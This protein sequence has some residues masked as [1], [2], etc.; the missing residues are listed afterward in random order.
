MAVLNRV[1]YFVVVLSAASAFGQTATLE[2]FATSRKNWDNTLDYWQASEGAA[3]CFNQT[4][5]VANNK[6]NMAIAG[7]TNGVCTAGTSNNS[8]F[9]LETM[10]AGIHG[11]DHYPY[12]YT[13]NYI[14]TGTWTA[15]YNRLQFAFVCDA[16]WI[17]P[18]DSHVGTYI[19]DPAITDA[20]YQGQHYYHY[21]QYNVR[22]RRPISVTINDT[23]DHIVGGKSI[24]MPRDP[25]WVLPSVGTTPL[26][27]FDNMTRFYLVHGYWAGA[28]TARTCSVSNFVFSTVANEPDEYVRS[29]AVQHTGSAYE[30]VWT[31]PSRTSADYEVRYSTTQSLKTVGFTNG[32]PAG[33]VSAAVTDIPRVTWTS[34]AMAEAPSMWVGI[35]P[36]PYVSGATNTSPIRISTRVDP[37]FTTGDSVQVAG[38]VGNTAANGTWKVTAVPR[39]VFRSTD[40]TLVSFVAA[41]AND[42]NNALLTASTTHGLSVGMT[43]QLYDA[44]AGA[45][46]EFVYGTS[47]T[48]TSVP[49][50]TTFTLSL[51][52]LADGTYTTPNVWSDPVLVL[53]GSTGNGTYTG[54]GTVTPLS[55]T[56][57]FTEVHLSSTVPVSSCDLTGDG[58]VDSHDVSAA[59]SAAL[60][61]SA[62]KAD[63]SGDGSCDV[64]DVQRVINAANG[65][66]CRLGP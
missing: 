53:V 33:T 7:C 49:S 10:P 55:E 19:R 8:C 24:N 15:A 46:E 41:H 42:P 36:H 50:S 65:L 27:Y 26:H 47:Y 62:C 31:A 43:V 21:L 66:G 18:E 35:R 28:T 12:T 60:K 3:Q 32:T 61:Q 6:G 52:N 9:Y 25:E 48:I 57:N 58:T 34:S 14:K 2:D 40:G 59:V 37:M 5:S 11:Y 17:D 56:T 30:V 39:T 13:K 54:G 1:V 45:P 63:I 64:I 20:A 22:A 4:L 44:T 23:I 29:I 16:D 51:P 38:V